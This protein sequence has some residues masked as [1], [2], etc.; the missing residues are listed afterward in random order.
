MP[1]SD[2]D[3]LLDQIIVTSAEGASSH[4]ATPVQYQYED[5][6]GHTNTVIGR[7]IGYD[8]RATM[9]LTDGS[10][11]ELPLTRRTASRGLKLARDASSPLD[12][13]LRD[14]ICG[15]AADNAAERVDEA[16]ADA[17]VQLA[18]FGEILHTR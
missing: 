5:D 3:F 1:V 16:S 7:Q 11:D 8:T 18:M 14:L 17:I 12:A 9:R 2:R 10:R 6:R 13:P 4:W 15:L